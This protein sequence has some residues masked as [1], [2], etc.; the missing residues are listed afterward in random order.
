MP[1]THLTLE[2]DGSPVAADALA[3]MLEVQ[4]EEAA[5]EADAATVTATLE[6]GAQGDWTSFLDPLGTP[7]TPIAIELARGSASYRFEGLSTEAEWQ[8]APDGVSR[9]T[10]KAIDRTL[11]M[12]VEEK[13]VS[14]P[15]TS[16]SG[17]A[18]GIFGNYGF[19]PDVE[20]TPDSPDPDVHVVV[21]RATDWSFLRSLADKWGYAVY[22][23]STPAGIVGT[24]KPI[25]PQ[26]EPQAQLSLGFGGDSADVSVR[27]RLLGGRE[28]K[29]SWMP[30]L[31]DQ[32]LSGDDT[33]QDQAQGETP[34]GG[35]TTVLLSPA[36]VDG[37]VDPQEAAR[38][39]ARRASFAVELSATVDADRIDTVL[40]ARRTVL[41][42]GLGAVLSGTYLVQRVRHRVTR[43]GHA[44]QLTLVRNALGASL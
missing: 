7:R 27:A 30:P 6:P 34:L 14:W 11:D 32:V 16:D 4:A 2:I 28:V 1:D 40:R 36:E 29:A 3:Q 25:D 12:N 22:V 23:E 39:L 13:V 24:F 33:G 19:T 31:S 21:Q 35:Q 10:V 8:I 41:V 26:A 9:L 15:G 17:I 20:T 42:G 18:Q 44:Q 38:G 43:D 5:D 37:E